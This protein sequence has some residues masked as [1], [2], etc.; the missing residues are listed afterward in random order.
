MKAIDTNAVVRFLTK[1]DEKQARLVHH[2]FLETEQ[3]GG[4]LFIS[5]AVILETMWVLSSVYQCSRQ[6]IISAIENLMEMPILHLENRIALT[7]LCQYTSSVNIDLADLLIGLISK[8]AGCETTLTFDR[9]AVKSDL[10]T[11]IA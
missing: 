8:E 4:T 9:K 10:F 3:S 5:T 2:L 6:K 1:D 7:T 11:L